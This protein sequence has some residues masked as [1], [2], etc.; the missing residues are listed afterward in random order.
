MQPMLQDGGARVTVVTLPLRVCGV[1]TVV[2]SATACQVQLAPPQQR[3][4]PL[5]RRC[6]ALYC[7]VAFR[8]HR[9]VPDAP[10]PLPFASAVWEVPEHRVSRR[11]PHVDVVW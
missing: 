10:S 1:S 5:Y 4:V 3:L 6:H 11:V 7:R 9:S 2:E 8:R